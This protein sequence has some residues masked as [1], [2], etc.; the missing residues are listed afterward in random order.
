MQESLSK[1]G[2]LTR[3]EL[4]GS[5]GFP[6]ME[7]MEKG[8]VACIECMEEIPCNPCE[9]VCPNGAIS[10][11]A[12]MTDLPVLDEAKCNGCGLC[13]P[14]CPG[15]AIFIVDKSYSKDEALVGLPYEMIPLPAIGQ[16]VHGVDREGMI[17]CSARVVKILNPKKFDRTPV[18]FIAIPKAFAVDVRNLKFIQKEG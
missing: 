17:L 10:I 1:T 11:G 3:E 5:L 16:K 12:E 15:L 8:P 6:S 9:F 13:V 18:I 4:S 14:V 7:R 2:I